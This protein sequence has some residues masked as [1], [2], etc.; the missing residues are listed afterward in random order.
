MYMFMCPRHHNTA[1]H[2]E[3]GQRKHNEACLPIRVLSR[4]KRGCIEGRRGQQQQQQRIKKLPKATDIH[5]THLP[6]AR[7]HTGKLFYLCM[8]YSVR[9]KSPNG[10]GI[11]KLTSAAYIR[12]LVEYKSKEKRELCSSADSSSSRQQ[13]KSEELVEPSIFEALQLG[14]KKDKRPQLLRALVLDGKRYKPLTSATTGALNLIANFTLVSVE[15]VSLDFEY[16]SSSKRLKVRQSAG[17]PR[18]TRHS[19][20]RVPISSRQPPAVAVAAAAAAAAPP[21]PPP[22]PP[23]SL[24]VPTAKIAVYNP[25]SRRLPSAC[26]R[27]RLHGTV[28]IILDVRTVDRYNA[29]PRV[30]SAPILTSYFAIHIYMRGAKRHTTST[31]RDNIS[32]Y[33]EQA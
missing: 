28:N 4:R 18:A 25:Y 12:G 32:Q 27:Y 10:E 26:A 7:T 3:L 23:Q 24:R 9:K 20:R 30:K 19:K 14:K 1:V 17:S 2:L 22:P 6:H 16:R 15:R 5:V 8:M 33:T 29:S 31:E 11:S 21:P 13:D